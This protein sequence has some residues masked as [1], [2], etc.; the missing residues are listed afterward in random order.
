MKKLVM[1]DGEP[2]FVLDTNEANYQIYTDLLKI[3]HDKYQLCDVKDINNN[4]IFYHNCNAYFDSNGEYKTKDGRPFHLEYDLDS[5]DVSDD[6]AIKTIRKI[7][8]QSYNGKDGIHFT[9]PAFNNSLEDIINVPVE[10]LPILYPEDD[11][12]VGLVEPEYIYA[13]YSCSVD[14]NG[15][16]MMSLPYYTKDIKAAQELINLENIIHRL[17]FNGKEK[18]RWYEISEIDVQSNKTTAEFIKSTSKEITLEDV[19]NIKPYVA[20]CIT[21][22]EPDNYDIAYPSDSPLLNNKPLYIILYS[23]QPKIEKRKFVTET[24]FNTTTG[25]LYI[26]DIFPVNLED[27][28]DDV[29]VTKKTIYSYLLNKARRK[30]AN[31]AR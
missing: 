4:D 22:Y 27:D 5:I 30:I 20:A 17:Y 1:K 29:V 2:I 23:I 31:K 25:F 24:R 12:P 18:S 11:E 14:S 19:K 21:T 3:Y 7:T 28:E 6:T 16:K 15:D 26:S 10:S 13:I 8:K 9:L